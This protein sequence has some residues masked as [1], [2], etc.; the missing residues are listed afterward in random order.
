M[1]ITICTGNEKLVYRYYLDRS[2]V[3][4]FVESEKERNTTQELILITCN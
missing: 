3:K 2:N 4:C 1:T